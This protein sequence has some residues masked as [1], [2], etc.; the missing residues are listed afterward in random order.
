MLYKKEEEKRSREMAL[1]E[2]FLSSRTKRKNI[3]G[4]ENLREIKGITFEN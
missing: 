1:V 3:M 4:S 2:S